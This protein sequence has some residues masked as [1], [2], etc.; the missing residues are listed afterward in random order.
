MTHASCYNGSGSFERFEF[1]GDSILDNIVVTAM[2]SRNLSHF[3]MHLLRTALVNADFLAF[4]C[5]EWSIEHEIIDLQVPARSNS[6][7]ITERRKAVPW[8]LWR[9]M[10]HL[11]PKLGFEQAA[12]TTRFAELRSEIKQAIEHGS[13]YPWALLSRLR[14][15]KYYSDLVESL[16]GAVWIDSGSFDICKGIV[17]R[18][19]ILPYLERILKDRVEVLHPKENLGILADDR[20]VKYVM[21]KSPAENEGARPEGLESSYTCTVF[22]GEERIVSMSGCIEKGILQT[23]TAEKAVEILKMRV[24]QTDTGVADAS[25]DI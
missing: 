11:S 14:A 1:L 18:M 5:M 13:Q 24:T 3:Q 16:L 21:D 10:R 25:M 23:M 2:W 7:K 8:P 19:G 22:V 17:H 20:T 15:H 12:M 9:F 6:S 4:I